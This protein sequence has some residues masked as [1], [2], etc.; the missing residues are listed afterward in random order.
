MI[1]SS[2]THTHSREGKIGDKKKREKTRLG[3]RRGRLDL[4]EIEGK[5]DGAMKRESRASSSLRLSLLLPSY[6]GRP[7]NVDLLNVL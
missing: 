3:R 6:G 5:W 7:T 2:R 1:F 4:F